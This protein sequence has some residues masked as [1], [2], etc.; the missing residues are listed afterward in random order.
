MLHFFKKYPSIVLIRIFICG[1]FLFPCY[2]ILTDLLICIK[3]LGLEYLDSTPHSSKV[4]HYLEEY[5]GDVCD[6]MQ[7]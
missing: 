6:Q 4:M 3:N 5:S 2:P 1:Y 7:H